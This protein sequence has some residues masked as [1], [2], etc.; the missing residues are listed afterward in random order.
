M[1]D[2]IFTCGGSTIRGCT[3]ATLWNFP[4][5]AY[6]QPDDGH[7]PTLG[8]HR[9]AAPSTSLGRGEHSATQSAITQPSHLYGG[10]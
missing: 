10:A 5:Q 3:L 8:M 2:A 1:L 7:W 9:G 6:V 4:W